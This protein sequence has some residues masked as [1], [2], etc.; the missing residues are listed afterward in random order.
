MAL[1][2]GSTAL[3]ID[4]S[5][6]SV[7]SVRTAANPIFR[8]FHPDPTICRN[9]AD[10]YVAHSSFEYFPGVTIFHSR[11]LVQ[12]EP[13][14]NVLSTKEQLDLTNI[15]ASAGIFAPTL[16][17]H[18]GTY[19]LVT[20]LVRRTEPKISGERS[21]N[22]IVTATSPTGPWSAP[23]WIDRAPGIDPSLFFD[24]DGSVYLCGNLRPDKVV[25]ESHRNIW[26]RKLDLATWTL[27]GPE[28]ILDAEPYYAQDKIGLPNNFEGPHLYKKDGTY[29]LLISHGGTG[30]N[31]ALSIWRSPNPLGPWEENPSNPILT[32]RKIRNGGLSCTGHGDLVQAEDGRW[33]MVALGIRD[34]KGFSPMGRETLLAPVDWSGA[35]PVINPGSHR[36]LID[37]VLIPPYPASGGRTTDEVHVGFDQDH[38]PLDWKTIRTPSQTWWDLKGKL[39]WLT[40]ALRPDQLSQI[41][42]PSWYGLP[43]TEL[44]CEATTTLVFH[45][46]NP[47]ECVGLAILRS[48]AA[49]WSL[50]IE[51]LGGGTEASVYEGSR[52]LG[53]LGVDVSQPV[54]LKIRVQFPRLFFAV[55]QGGKPWT[56]ILDC[57]AARMSTDRDGRFTGAMIGVYAS[58]RGE[59]STRTAAFD[60]FHYIPR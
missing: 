6:P 23:H 15:P 4:A 29:Y 21:G 53:A 24:D 9:G 12:W 50:V 18:K 32:H 46:G 27:V 59:K 10:F 7:P 14:S 5:P 34:D 48:Q 40:L 20:T 8:G 44:T 45:P 31:H 17:Y 28:G 36:G 30:I 60:A 57:D 3:A 37:P 52:R 22:F 25:R 38:M 47:K 43:V 35:W 51:N 13:V 2:L 54:E 11:D 56:A 39:G 26:I 41:S 55:R 16:R 1:L 49:C 58:S 19:Y 33:W 42:Q